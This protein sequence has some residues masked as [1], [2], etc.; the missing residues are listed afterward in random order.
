MVMARPL[1]ESEFAG[2]V[3]TN[4][5]EVEEVMAAATYEE[6]E[7]DIH[8]LATRKAEYITLYHPDR[9]NPQSTYIVP[10]NAGERRLRISRLLSK[11]KEVNG[12][13]VRWNFP[14]PQV[15][16][17]DL[18]LRCFVSGCARRGGFQ[19]RSQLIAH[20]QGKHGNEA[21]MYQRL[22]DALMEQIYRD[23]PEEQYEMY[24]L[25]RPDD[26]EGEVKPGR[27]DTSAFTCSVCGKEAKST[28]G[29][30]SH[31]RSHNA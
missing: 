1:N 25:K 2:I 29:L 22:I 17:R 28:F 5:N 6:A 19:S 21:P 27:L 9:D 16:G 20:V 8:P 4:P 14:R 31:M 12:Q 10:M 7:K 15:E 24:G 11:M 26:V 30:N 13:L 18:P 3:P 23:I